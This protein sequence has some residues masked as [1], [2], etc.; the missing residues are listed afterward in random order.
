MIGQITYPAAFIRNHCRRSLEF[1]HTLQDIDV[2][3]ARVPREFSESQK[4]IG[5]LK[6]S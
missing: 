1:H 2:N 5:G 4:P 3:R 6:H